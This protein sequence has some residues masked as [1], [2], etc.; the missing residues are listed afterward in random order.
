[1]RVQ[2]LNAGLARARAL[3]FEE[4]S[5]IDNTSAAVLVRHNG[6]GGHGTPSDDDVYC[7]TD[8]RLNVHTTYVSV[9]RYPLVALCSVLYHSCDCRTAYEP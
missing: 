2:D 4:Y 8:R 7:T 6:G 5:K 9:L 3:A 1:M